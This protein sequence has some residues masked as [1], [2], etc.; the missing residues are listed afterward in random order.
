MLK[1]RAQIFRWG[2]LITMIVLIGIAL[3][4]PV[5]EVVPQWEILLAVGLIVIW[6]LGQRYERELIIEAGLA[7]SEDVRQVEREN[8]SWLF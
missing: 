8:S 6:G 3:F 5:R 4:D 2:G 7:D 1:S